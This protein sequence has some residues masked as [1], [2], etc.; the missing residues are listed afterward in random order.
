MKRLIGIFAATLL[1]LLVLA[2]AALAEDVGTQRDGRVLIAIG[3]DLTLPAGER[4]DAVIV[5]GGTAT[6]NGDVET[7]VSID[8][9]AHLDGAR[10]ET[11]VAIG[12]PVEL[13]GGTVV[14]G[15]VLTLGSDVT[16][17]TG[18]RVDGAVRDMWPGIA[19][20][21]AILAPA[22]ILLFIGFALAAIAAALLLA[23]LAPRQIR[24]AGELIRHE[25]A[26]TI[27]VGL[28]GL[29]APVVLLIALT[30]TV[31]GAPLAFGIA[32]GLWPLAAFLG[33]LVAGILIGEWIL[34]R[35]SPGVIRERPYL[36][37]VVG[38]LALQVISLVPLV[39]GI[40]SFLGY[41]AVLLLAWRILR[42]GTTAAPLTSQRTP[43]L[44]PG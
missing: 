15:D 4:A 34:G 37:A 44:S 14:S 13:I 21:G 5:I 23:G 29:I 24:A 26:L 17:A 38:M 25:T 35:T 16:Q 39:G 31:I 27:G 22:L 19:V 9:R 42:T 30:V 6:I 12:G 10:T 41:G 1:V 11:V 2:P 20:M 18:V 28:L 43:A 32:F 33:Y 8:G 3:G 7:I 40:A 36:A